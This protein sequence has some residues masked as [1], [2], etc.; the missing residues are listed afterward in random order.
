MSNTVKLDVEGGCL[1][2]EHIGFTLRTL[3]AVAAEGHTATGKRV[4]PVRYQGTVIASVRVKTQR[5]KSG[6]KND[7]NGRKVE[8]SRGARPST[9]REGLARSE[10]PSGPNLQ[11]HSADTGTDAEAG[12]HPALEP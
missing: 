6:V 5:V 3:L 1:H 11:A 12:F 10:G 8:T 9:N 4:W 7:S 2:V